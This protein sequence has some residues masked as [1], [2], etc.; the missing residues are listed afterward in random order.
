MSDNDAGEKKLPGKN[1]QI[2]LFVV[3]A[4]IAIALVF[5][6]K[7][8]GSVNIEGTS[9]GAPAPGGAPTAQPAGAPPQK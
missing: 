1:V 8:F 4:V 6:V 9:T 5:I 2:V 7:P 3:F